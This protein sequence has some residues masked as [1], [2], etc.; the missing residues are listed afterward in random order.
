VASQQRVVTLPGGMVRIPQIRRE[1]MASLGGEER[2]GRSPL[3]RR[4]LPLF[5]ALSLVLVAMALHLA[6]RPFGYTERTGDLI[7]EGAFDRWARVLLPGMAAAEVGEGGRAF[8]ALLLPVA[9][10]MLPLF[11]DLGVRIPWRYDP[12]N[13]VSR[14]VTILGL[15]LVFGIRLRREL[16]NEL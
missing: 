11:A 1:L 16:R 13:L 14:V 2:A 8:L 5:V 6:R 15:A 3:L 4:G 12:G 9:L 10:L 7:P